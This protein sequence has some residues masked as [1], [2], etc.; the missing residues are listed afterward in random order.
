MRLLPLLLV[1]AALLSGCTTERKG[2]VGDTLQ[3]RTVSARLIEIDAGDRYSVDVG[4][5]NRQDAAIIAWHFELV[6]DDGTRLHPAFATGAHEFDV[7]RRGCGRGW[8]RYDVPHGATPT[9]LDYR[10]DGTD[11]SSPAN[12]NDTTEHDHF[13]WSL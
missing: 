12:G 13:V 8:I 5:C 11:G 4:V 6:L 7:R 9:S 10:Y 3:A 2:A 1:A